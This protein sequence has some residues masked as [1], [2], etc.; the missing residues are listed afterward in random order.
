M[1]VVAD[2]LICHMQLHRIGDQRFGD[3]C[4]RESHDGEREER[5]GGETKKSDWVT[6]LPP[7][8]NDLLL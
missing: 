6:Q 8:P 1:K 5:R 2:R 3:Q 4:D 7:V